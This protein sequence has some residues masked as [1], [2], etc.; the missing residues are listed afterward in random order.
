MSD[1]FLRR[2]ARQL[3]KPV[4]ELQQSVGKARR[5]VAGDIHLVKENRG[6]IVGLLTGKAPPQ[7]VAMRGTYL[8]REIGGWVVTLTAAAIA[9]WWASHE[10][11]FVA[12]WIVLFLVLPGLVMAYVYNRLASACEEV[13]HD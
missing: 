13:D 5:E 6:L 10:K 2:R 3:G 1:N 8:G 9:G 7:P 4:A 11:F 12:A